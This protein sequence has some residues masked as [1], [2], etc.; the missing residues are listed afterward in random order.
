MTTSASGMPIRPTGRFVLSHPAHFIAFGFGSGLMRPAP[1]TAGTLAALPIYWAL[2]PRLTDLQF[3]G[4]IVALFVIGI[5]AC[6]RTGRA[7]G[8]P[9]HGGMVI[10][11]IV[12]YL[13]VLFMI[14]REFLWQASGFVLFRAFD[15]VKPMPIRH[16]DRTVKGGFGVMLDDLL[17]AFYTLLVLAVW[18]RAMSGGLI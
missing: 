12:A 3:L 5:W 15:I 18:R 2:A 6:G 16:F 14:P 9:D 10:D 4:V 11:E 13:L 17:A 8:V 7:L 1:G